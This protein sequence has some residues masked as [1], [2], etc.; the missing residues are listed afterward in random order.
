MSTAELS[1]EIT[2][3]RAALQ[4]IAA[5]HDG[6]VVSIAQAALCWPEKPP[7]LAAEEVD[8]TIE[9]LRKAGLDAWDKIDDPE[10]FIRELRE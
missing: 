7:W 5:G 4:E 3:L 9:E 1:A 8:K 10:A 2:R 6:T